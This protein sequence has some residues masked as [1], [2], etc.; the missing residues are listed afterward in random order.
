MQPHD[1]PDCTRSTWTE[2]L[3]AP[4]E[5][6]G[7]LVAAWP[8]EGLERFRQDARWAGP[9]AGVL[10]DVSVEELRCQLR[11][12]LG[13]RTPVV[14]TGHQ[15]EFFH[16]GV[17]AKTIAAAEL[18]GA[19][20]GDALFVCV[21]SD[22]PRTAVLA[23]PQVTSAG[24][25]RV[26]VNIPG[27]DTSVPYEFQPAVP[28]GHWL[29]FFAR[30]GAL[31]EGYGQSL[32]GAFARGW[33]QKEQREVSY[34]KAMEAGWAASEAALG[35]HGVRPLPVS[36]LGCTPAF[37]V[38]AAHLLLHAR[39]VAECYN[40]AQSAYRVR[41][42][43]RAAGRPV[44][45]LRLTSEAVESPMWA[46]RAGETRRRVFVRWCGDELELVADSS[47][48]VR[49][50]RADLER[51]AWH[52]Q[53]WPIERA[54]W[55]LRPRALTLS[56]F[57]RLLV[58]DLFI[59]G[60]GGARYD[61]MT[62]EFVRDFFGLSM[63]PLLCVSATLHLPLP[64]SRLRWADILAARRDS[65]DLRYNPQRHLSNIPHGLV[66]QRAE[67]VRRS[68]ELAAHD[69]QDRTGR[70]LLFAAIRRVNEQMLQTDPWA[71][72]KYD[73]RVRVL[74]EQWRLDRIAL[75]RE[76]FYALHA[77]EALEEL[78]RRLRQ[79]LGLEAGVPLS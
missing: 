7:V 35:L 28:R 32:L 15:P 12:E 71:A 24:V 5:H 31:Y 64:H 70:R 75:D 79:R 52:R 39:R 60:I 19:A 66:A 67:L 78:S 34:V 41:H 29:Q 13:L 17:F 72:A 55:Q 77:P 25:R 4:D 58:G 62:E 68:Q 51:S 54:G 11:A 65:R 48:L 40:A 22:L 45:P 50:R 53:P 1:M 74:E 36:R 69:P 30:V 49:L 33:L 26:D 56:T 20:H 37:R 61:E 14:T 18:A 44:P 46:V 43:V 10:L 38:F 59:H 2:S 21:D 6:L 16:A 23:V 63:S 73:E 47:P 42:R 27:I 3:V 8:R 76:Y 9:T 57:L